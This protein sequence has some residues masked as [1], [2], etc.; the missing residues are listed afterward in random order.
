VVE[1]SLPS[2]RQLSVAD[3]EGQQWLHPADYKIHIGGHVSGGANDAVRDQRAE[4]ETGGRFLFIA[5]ATFFLS[6]LPC[7]FVQSVSWQCQSLSLIKTRLELNALV[8]ATG[9][10]GGCVGAEHWCEREI[11]SILWIV[12][13]S[14][15]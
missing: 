9:H 4:N 13:A 3:A 2:A 14:Q 10:C 11:V 1:L 8:V 5:I 15:R 6:N 12:F 7:V